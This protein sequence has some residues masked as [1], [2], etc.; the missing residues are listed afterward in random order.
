[1]MPPSHTTER[2]QIRK[3]FRSYAY[4]AMINMIVLALYNIVD[5]IFIGQGA[6]PLAICGL[7][8]TLP[9]VSLLGTVGTLTGV[10][11]AARISAAI[12]ASNYKLATRV[13]GNAVFLNVAMNLI[14]IVY[15]LFNLDKIL[16]AF[17][18]SEQTIPYA[19]SYLSILIPGSLLTNLNFTFCHAIRASGFPRKSM[20]II[21]TGVIA[22]LILDPVF[23]FGFNMGI[24]GAAIATVISMCISS[25]LIFSHFT[26]KQNTLR[27][28]RLSFRPDL[29][30]L[31]TII[32]VGMA[33]FIMNITT[34]M[35]NIIM[36]RYLV[37]YGGDYAIG[38][39]GIISSYSI[40]VS[41]LLMGIC[42]SMQPIIS[43][44]YATG[45]REVLHDTLK[46][47]IGIGSLIASA[48]FI[49][50]ETGATWLVKA[51]TWDPQLR[52]ISAEGLRYTFLAMPLVG[53]QIIVT[54]YFQSIRQAP[55][56]ITMNISRQFV[57]L[58]PA[59]SLFSIWWGL[60]GI[61]LAIPFADLMATLIAL[62]FILRQARTST[63]N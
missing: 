18:G 47:A 19:H 29:M 15:S 41:M 24:R 44:H 6:G 11:G 37:N 53:F 39:Y 33:A 8:L 56:A 1:M 62:F 23:I 2:T 26:G 51:F 32:G 16:L 9:C 43:Y 12:S 34:G 38:A 28:V 21:L 45:H 25:V 3:L 58:I 61:W 59:L 40:L 20:M 31:L 14:L 60:T 7:A 36:N 46:Y 55:K 48:G 17:G 22:N 27:L 50:G 13:L 5:R 35:V 4:P 57:F 52:D 54:S 49:I 10:G 63:L 42:Q 30:I